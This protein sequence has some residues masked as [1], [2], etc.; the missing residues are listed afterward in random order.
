MSWSAGE[1]DQLTADW[2][3]AAPNPDI[4]ADLLHRVHAWRTRMRWI[5]AG[6][7]AL[8]IAI[9]GCALAVLR[10]RPPATL[11]LA[12]V[13]VYIAVVWAFALWNRHGTTHPA[14]LAM[15]D[16]IDLLVLRCHRRV[17]SARFTLIMVAIHAPLAAALLLAGEATALRRLAGATLIVL[18]LAGLTVAAFVMRARARRE[19][20][21][22]AALRSN[23]DS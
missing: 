21:R 10:Q 23:L 8:T 17:R 7:I 16:C 4:A 3:A 12:W 5:V 1:W 11:W 14:S 20:D 2:Q 6:E 13:G 15:R 22:L 9:G 19:L 18:T